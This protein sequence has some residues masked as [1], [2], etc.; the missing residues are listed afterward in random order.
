MSSKG[1][2]YGRTFNGDHKMP[3]CEQRTNGRT[4]CAEHHAEAMGRLKPVL[5]DRVR[6]WP[7]YS[8][9]PHRW[10]VYG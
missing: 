1:C 3:K 9:K 10:A 2:E 4:F 6:H 5:N 7:G 8:K